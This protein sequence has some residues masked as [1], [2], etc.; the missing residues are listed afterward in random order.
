MN[1]GL[2]QKLLLTADNTYQLLSVL[3]C[4]VKSQL[5]HRPLRT[6]LR[7]VVRCGL[8]NCNVR[9]VHVCQP[10]ATLKILST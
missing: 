5:T 1:A 8:L 3:G 7:V 4:E 6:F 9:Q 2:T 10:A